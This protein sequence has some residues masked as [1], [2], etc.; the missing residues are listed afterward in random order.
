MS[1][2][3]RLLIYA[4]TGKDGR[5]LAGVLERAQ[6]ACHVCPQANDVFEEMAKGAGAVILADE[7]LSIEFLKTIRRLLDNQPSWSD[8]PFLVLRQTAPDTP[9][10]RSRYVKLGNVTLLDRPVRSVTLVSAATSALRAR[11]RQ[12]EMREIDRRK[13]EFLAMLAHE[14]RNP[15]A[16]ISAASRLLSIP[17]LDREKIKH[18][19]DIISRQVRHMTGLIDDLLDVS[20]VSRGLV[21]LDQGI[22]DAWQIVAS[23]VEQVRPLMDARQHQ[24]TVRDSPVSA[25]IFGDQKRLVQIIANI[26]NN[27][28]KYTPVGGH[29]ALTVDVDDANVVFTV[30]DDGIGMEPEVLERVFNMFAQGERSSDRTQGGLGIGL[31]IVKSLVHLH[32]G[33]ITAHSDGLGTGSTFTLTL[34]RVA[35]QHRAVENTLPEVQS[36]SASHS[37]LIVDDNV[38]AAVTLGNILEISGYDVSIEHSAKAALERVADTAPSVCLLDIG[39]PDMDGINLARQL[40]NRP[41]TASSLMIAIT[42]YGQN[43]DRQKSLHAGFDHHLVKPVDLP[44]L[45][46]ILSSL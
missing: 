24:L 5:L 46:S 7:A 19:S 26:L 45:L 6:M 35:D 37:I 15:L 42:G 3:K 18:T 8:F 13:D 34:P 11:A 40:R 20:R 32:S 33:K 1:A 39:L 28:A 44:Q 43:S 36:A 31:A 4:P 38:D 16:P 22:Q 30:R 12:Y 21:R 2:E 25:S 29:I 10:M 17:T 9:E 41:N 27:A 23:A 14:L